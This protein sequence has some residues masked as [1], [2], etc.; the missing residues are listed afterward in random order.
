MHDPSTSR[1]LFKKTF[2]TESLPENF[3][4]TA[5]SQ[6]LIAQVLDAEFLAQPLIHGNHIASEY[7]KI[8]DRTVQFG[9]HFL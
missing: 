9:R 8:F 6:A 5:T 4:G 1:G 2:F 3:L 7:Q